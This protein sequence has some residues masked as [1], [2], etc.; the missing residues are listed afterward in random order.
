MK[1][2]DIDA[3][4]PM[5]LRV[6]SNRD[7]FTLEQDPED[8]NFCRVETHDGTYNTFKKAIVSILLGQG[9]WVL[10][11]DARF[12]TPPEVEYIKFDRDFEVGRSVDLHD[13]LNVLVHDLLEGRTNDAQ[14]SHMVIDKVIKFI[15]TE[16]KVKPDFT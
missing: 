8:D 9:N 2:R 1:I 7:L 4:L 15:R 16:C 5:E 3:A 11:S 10:A 13:K 14:T 12:I 6:A